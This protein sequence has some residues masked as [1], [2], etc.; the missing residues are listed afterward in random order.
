MSL[1]NCHEIDQSIASSQTSTY[2]PAPV[3]G[4]DGLSNVD[5]SIIGYETNNTSIIVFSLTGTVGNVDTAS[6]SPDNSQIMVADNT[7]D[8]NAPAETKYYSV[9]FGSDTKDT[10]WSLTFAN[11]SGG[12]WVFSK[13][14]GSKS[15]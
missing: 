3:P 12:T 11:S 5:I 14:K 13:A 15:W 9:N 6:L 1:S 7:S 10:E 4:A 8:P 2:D